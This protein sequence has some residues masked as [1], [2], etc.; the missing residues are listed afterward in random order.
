M[1]QRLAEVLQGKED[2][3]LLP[4]IWQRGEEEAVIREE[5]S[6]IHP[7]GIRVVCV[8][9]RPHPD[10]LGPRWGHDMDIIL[11][12]ARQREKGDRTTGRRL[13]LS[14]LSVRDRP[15]AAPR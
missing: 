13:H 10:F 12:E 11:Q 3:Y 15:G 6:R 5:I 14:A 1:T 2:N 9:A 8:E 7:S 4:F